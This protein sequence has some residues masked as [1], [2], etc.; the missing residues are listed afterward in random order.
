MKNARHFSLLFTISFSLLACTL[1]SWQ[2]DV[3]KP[4]SSPI[5]L[6]TLTVIA[7]VA[8]AT[9]FNTMT[10]LKSFYLT[11]VIANCLVGGIYLLIRH[12]QMQ[13]KEFII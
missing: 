11:A 4:T 13:K 1:S 8:D 12:G 10:S 7:S 6:P 9:P 3:L 2:E 5:I